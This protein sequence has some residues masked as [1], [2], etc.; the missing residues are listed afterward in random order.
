MAI[1]I[2]ENTVAIIKIKVLT[3]PKCGYRPI[4]VAKVNTHVICPVCSA[5]IEKGR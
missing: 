3:C 5:K 2:K 4:P 1:K